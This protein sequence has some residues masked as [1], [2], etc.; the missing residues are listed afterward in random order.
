MCADPVDGQLI[1]VIACADSGTGT[2]NLN[3]GIGARHWHSN[4]T[5]Y[6]STMQVDLNSVGVNSWTIVYIEATNEWLLV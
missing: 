3:T 5:G 4:S 2:I 6:A 1:H